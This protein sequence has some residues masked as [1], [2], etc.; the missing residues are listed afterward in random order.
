MQTPANFLT[1]IDLQAAIAR[2][3]LLVS[4]QTTVKTAIGRMDETGSSYV[5]VVDNTSQNLTKDGLVGI[6]TERDLVRLNMQPIPLDQLSLQA[7]MSHPVITLYEADFTS[8]NVAMA[9]FQHHQ[10]RHLPILDSRD[11]LVGVLERETLTDRLA[12]NLLQLNAE[13]AALSESVAIASQP[14]ALTESSQPGVAEPQAEEALPNSE[15]FLRS[16]YE[17]VAQAIFTLDVL[18]DG[19]FRYVAFNPAAERLSGKTTAEIQGNAPGEKVRLRYVECVQTGSPITYEECLIFKDTPTW[20]LTTLNPIRD[21]SSR[22]YRIIGTSTS[23]T[24][25]KQAEARLEQ[26]NRELEQRIEERTAALQA[27]EERWQLVLQGTNAGLWD[28]NVTTNQVFF[29]SRWKTMHGFPDDA[30]VDR[31][32]A[33]FEAICPDDHDRVVAAIAEHFAG[34]TEFFELEYRMRHKDG[35]DVWVLDRGQAKRDAAGQVVRMSG[36][37][38][39]ITRRKQVENALRDS[40]RRYATLASAAPVAIFRFDVPLNCIYV[41]DRWS[42]MTGRPKESALGRGWVEALHPDDRD[43]LLAQYAGTYAHTLPEQRVLNHGEGRHLRPDGTINW[44]YVQVAQEI[45]T[46]G[47][48]LSYIGTL[49][50]IT[51]RKLVEIALQRSEQRYRALMDG[52][53]DAILLANAQGNLIEVNQKGEALLGYSRDELGHL[54]VSQ[55]HPPEALEAAYN[56]FRNVVQHNVGPILESIIVR[57]DGRKVPVDIT[58]SLIELDG[59]QIAQG[60]FRDISRRKQLEAEHKRMEADL[61]ESEAKFRRL[62][63][64]GNDLIWAAQVDGT[65]TYLSPQFETLFGWEADEWIGKPFI[66]LVH[67]DDRAFIASDHREKGEGGQQSKAVEFRHCHKDGHYRWVRTSATAILSPDGTVTGSQGILTDVSDRKRVEEA[68]QLSE[69]LFRNAFN[70]TAIGMGLSSAEGQFLKVNASICSFFGYSETE[71]LALTFQQLTH[72]DDLAIDLDLFQQMLEARHDSYTIEKRYIKQQGQVVWGLLSLSVVRDSHA[73]PL[74]FVA[75]VQDVTARKHVE[76]ALQL[77]EERFR[78]AFDNTAIGMC[79]VSPDGQYLKA[80]AA[81]C[82]FLGYSEAELLELTFQDITHPD[83]LTINLDYAARIVAGNVHSYHLEKRYFTKQGHTVWGLLSVSLTRDAQE[84]PLYFV[85]Q[86]QDIND[87]KLLEQEQHRLIAILEAST[88]YISMSDANGTIFWK[89]AELKRLCGIKLDEDVLQF[90]ITD[91]HPQWTADLLIQQGFPAAI[92]TG[93]WIGETALLNAEG[94]EIPVS[95][96]ILAHKSPQGNVEFFSFIMRDMRARKAYELQLQQSNAQLLRAT[97]LKDE[98]LANMSHELRTP[99]N[100][101]LGLSEGLQ[102]EVFGPLNERQKRAIATIERSGQHLLQLINDIL[103]VSKIA[104]G[105]LELDISTVSVTHLCTSSLAFVKQQ[106]FK[107]QIEL[108][109]SF[110]PANLGAIAVDERRMRQV[111]INLLTNAVKFTPIGGRVTLEVRLE[112]TQINLAERVALDR[113]AMPRPVVVD[114]VGACCQLHDYD[115]CIAVTDTGIGISPRDQ[116]KLFQPFTQIDSSLNRQYEGTGLGLALVK[117]IVELHGGSVS[118]QSE[119]NQG[120]CFTLHLPY[121]NVQGYQDGSNVERIEPETP[122][123]PS[124]AIVPTQAPDPAPLILIAE[125]NEANASTFSS[126]LTAKGYHVLLARNGQE[127]IHLA[128]TQRPDLILIDIQMPDMNGFEAMKQIRL[129]PDLANLPMIVL[130]ALAMAGDRERCLEAGATDYFAKPVKLKQLI[131]TIEHLLN[132]G[133]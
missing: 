97:R 21:G 125:D 65:L 43:H 133:K 119:L 131:T 32:E 34:N 67:P 86:I 88:D 37:A 70:N 121:A 42:E 124:L 14:P 60:I 15:P 80:N 84:Q 72:P 78:N 47:S 16:L 129:D 62:V 85:S 83:D 112:P 61:A 49:T 40:E 118:L 79:L 94:Q 74:Y 87:R 39:N 31:L 53:S 59:E 19:N 30:V 38:I 91:C 64:E 5:L 2:K 105:K 23:I 44:F 130:T 17:G 122:A 123:T 77:S 56:H 73:Q 100:A 6:L 45:D 104:A 108:V 18:E 29:S 9:L 132:P 99:L 111:L 35:S 36:S 3:L 22:I 81:L 20:W 126:Y 4:P 41:N 114:A 28:W 26:L 92:A 11:R 66:D 76:E 10:M 95:Q 75:Q 82:T 50:D 46:D 115:L 127:V 93:S 90:Q 54:H 107:K 13:T 113:S 117:Q 55:L 69:T 7:V 8:I 109:V 27:S 89:N 71:L 58:A 25:R 110:C 96:L 68:L 106:A 103:E 12:Q 24:E 116:T 102:E 52:A 101:I 57:K 48:V 1:P 98:F 120:S 33:W 51:D 63:E 128:K